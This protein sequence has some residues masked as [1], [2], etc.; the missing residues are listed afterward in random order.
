MKRM[1]LSNSNNNVNPIEEANPQSPF[2]SKP[3][4]QYRPLLG[5]TTGDLMA[6]G[7]YNDLLMRNINQS[8]LPAYE[9]MLVVNKL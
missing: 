7:E 6:D 2:Y 9:D 4:K 3:P 5:S 1:N 8:K